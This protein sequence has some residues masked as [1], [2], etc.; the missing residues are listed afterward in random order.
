MKPTF[1]N[2]KLIFEAIEKWSMHFKSLNWDQYRQVAKSPMNP[3]IV[4]L[5]S[6]N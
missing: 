5:Q 1:G 3:K 2:P 6:Q 4:V